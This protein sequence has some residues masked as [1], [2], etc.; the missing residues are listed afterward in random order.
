MVF[1][2]VILLATKG[3]FR[4]RGVV[5]CLSHVQ[6]SLYEILGTTAEQSVLTLQSTSYSS[7]YL[8]LYQ[9]PYTTVLQVLLRNKRI[10]FL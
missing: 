6:L 7:S 4:F 3:I 1:I 8:Y 5:S 9:E 10:H 2:S